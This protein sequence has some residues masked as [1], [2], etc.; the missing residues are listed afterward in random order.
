MIMCLPKHIPSFGGFVANK[1]IR[2]CLIMCLGQAHHLL[3]ATENV[4]IHLL[5]PYKEDMCLLSTILIGISTFLSTS[6]VVFDN[7]TPLVYNVCNG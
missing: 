3:I 1:H 5:P 2:M 4:F 6:L 7:Y